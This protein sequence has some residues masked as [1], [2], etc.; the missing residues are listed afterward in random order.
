MLY[1]K[2]GPGGREKGK[3]EIHGVKYMPLS[4]IRLF[5][6]PQVEQ[7]SKGKLLS[8]LEIAL[9]VKLSEK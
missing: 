1:S 2:E 6:S 5:S 3:R 8:S 7:T 4:N 9:L